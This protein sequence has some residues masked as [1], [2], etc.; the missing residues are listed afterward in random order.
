MYPDTNAESIMLNW[1][2]QSRRVYN[3]A[4]NERRDWIKSRKCAVNACSLKSEY[5][6]SAD[7][8][9]PNY[10][11]YS[12]SVMGECHYLKQAYS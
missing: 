10:Y 11:W 3:Y 9:Y 8:P 6:I 1:L 12:K 4:L 5:I 2:E 7:T